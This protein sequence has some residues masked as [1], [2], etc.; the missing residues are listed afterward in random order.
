VSFQVQALFGAGANSFSPVTSFSALYSN[1]VPLAY[2]TALPANIIAVG[3]GV[4]VGG[5]TVPYNITALQVT[6]RVWDPVTQ[7]SRQV[8]FVQEM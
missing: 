2:D 5:V 8:S 6:L 3:G 1:G 7:Q 4:T